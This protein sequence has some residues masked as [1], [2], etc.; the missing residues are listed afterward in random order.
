MNS[1]KHIFIFISCEGFIKYCLQ[2][3]FLVFVSLCNSLLQVFV[4]ILD[5]VV[6]L[7]L[8]NPTA[9]ILRFS[10]KVVEVGLCE[11]WKKRTRNCDV[12]LVSCG[13]VV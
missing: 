3:A 6:M 7:W 5:R 10:A 9:Y 8:F 13:I 4:G 2:Y 11:G 12:H 1:Y